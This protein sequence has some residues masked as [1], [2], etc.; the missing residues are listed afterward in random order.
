MGQ[1]G[2][3]TTDARYY[4]TVGI[5]DAISISAGIRF[6]CAVRADGSVWCWGE[7]PG[8]DGVS[9][10]PVQVPG[11]DDAT[12]VSAGGAFACALRSGGQVG[13]WGINSIG[14]LGNGRFEYNTGDATPQTVVGIDDATQIST[15]WNHACVIRSDRS[16]WCWGGNGDGVTG[17]GQL[18]DGTFDNSPVPVQVVGLSDVIKVAAGGWST[19]AIT[20]GGET[21]CWGYGQQGTLGDG[22]MADSNVPVQPGI[23][24]ARSVAVGM[25]EACVSRTDDS[26]WCWG[27]TFWGS[28]TGDPAATPVE[29][30]KSQPASVA[31]LTAGR[32]VELLDRHG[33][34]WL[35]SKVMDGSPYLWSVGQ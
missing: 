5:D 29:G 15:G 17:Y 34:V 32:V 31:S 8:S 27:D 20:A 30:N 25:F 33:R 22:N 28:S 7:D 18:G 23:S 21:W 24:D 16:L 10:I 6:S 3:G 12:A 4:P 35:W 13:C 19:C 9:S 26:V 2:D 1:L 11:I 14:Q